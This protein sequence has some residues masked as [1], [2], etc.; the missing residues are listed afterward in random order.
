M[1]G[2]G[3]EFFCQMVLKLYDF[4]GF[5]TLDHIFWASDIF[6]LGGGGLGLYCLGPGTPEVIKAAH[7]TQHWT[8]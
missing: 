6:F 2:L 7:V 8:R 1:S 3:H 4:L 5:G